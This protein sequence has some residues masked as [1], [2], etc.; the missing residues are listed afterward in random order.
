M[1]LC[2]LT[3]LKTIKLFFFLKERPGLG[4]EGWVSEDQSGDLS[5]PAKTVSQEKFQAI[6][7][8]RGGRPMGRKHKFLQ[9]GPRNLRAKEGPWDPGPGLQLLRARPALLGSE[10]EGQVAE[11]PLLELTM[12]GKQPN[13]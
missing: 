1:F 3:S 12:V 6:G 9:G 8:L 11:G 10:G 4:R 5:P 13:P 2:I 7:T